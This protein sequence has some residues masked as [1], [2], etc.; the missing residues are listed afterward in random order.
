V[1]SAPEPPC[2]D[3]SPINSSSLA[4]PALGETEMV[5]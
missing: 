3:F 2:Q 1:V 4:T 5:F